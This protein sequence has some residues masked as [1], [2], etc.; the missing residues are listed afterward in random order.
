[1]GTKILIFCYPAPQS[2]AIG[3]FKIRARSNQDEIQR[4]K[5]WAA[6]CQTAEDQN[7]Q[8]WEQR[9]S[10]F[11]HKFPI[12]MVIKY[13]RGFQLFLPRALQRLESPVFPSWD[14]L[15]FC[16]GGINCRG[17]LENQRLILFREF[18]VHLI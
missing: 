12:K 13:K 8:K 11:S 4:L 10:R 1:M 15:S 2:A 5:C 18:N 7:S 14:G 9:T 17:R 3:S 16:T 6:R